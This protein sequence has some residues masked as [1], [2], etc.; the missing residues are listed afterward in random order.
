[1]SCSNLRS[2]RSPPIC[3]RLQPTPTEPANSTSRRSNGPVPP[4]SP[5]PSCQPRSAARARR[6]PRWARSC[7][8]SAAADPAVTVTLAMHSHLVAAQVWRHQH[9][10]D[11]EPFLRKVAGRRPCA[12]I[13][14]GAC[15]LG[16]LRTA[17]P[18]RSDGGFSSSAA[19]AKR[20]RV[21]AA[22]SVTSSSRASTGPTPSRRSVHSSDPVHCRGAVRLHARPRWTPATATSTGVCSTRCRV[23][24]RPASPA[25]SRSGWHPSV[26]SAPAAVEQPAHSQPRPTR[27]PEAKPDRVVAQK[28]RSMTLHPLTREDL[29]SEHVERPG[30]D[31]RP[32]SGSFATSTGRT[33]VRR[34][35]TASRQRCTRSPVEQPARAQPLAPHARPEAT[36]RSNRPRASA[37]SGSSAPSGASVSAR[38]VEEVA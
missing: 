38:P 2:R 22:R 6:T 7:A 12:P 27:P 3:G 15:R 33:S 36:G 26:S 11:A 35:P 19:C 1:M 34:V 37:A 8:C 17:R 30:A 18:P 24:S 28:E 13:S 32:E 20:R 4:V 23:P 10:I 25:A 21:R 9:G 31:A 16:P 14:T 29:A 5:P